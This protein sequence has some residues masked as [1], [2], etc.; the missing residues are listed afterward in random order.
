MT[1]LRGGSIG[2]PLRVLTWL[3]HP[4]AGIAKPRRANVEMICPTVT[5]S[6]RD[7]SFAACNTSSSMS[8][9][10]LTDKVLMHHRIKVN[11]P[12]LK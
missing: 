1:S 11:P 10:V 5:P 7:I 12:R 4:A 9:V 6:R 8:K 2:T 3:L